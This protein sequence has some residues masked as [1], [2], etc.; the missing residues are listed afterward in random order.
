MSLL[1]RLT[2]FFSSTEA[3]AVSQTGSQAAIVPPVHLDQPITNPRLTAAIQKH[4]QFGTDKTAAELFDELTSSVLLVGIVLDGVPARV[5]GAE[6]LFRQGDRIGV[7]EVADDHDNTLLGLFTDQ[8]QVQQFTDKANSTVVLPAADAMR[9]VLA[10]GY[11]GLVV[12]PASE[13]SLRL[14]AALIRSS[15]GG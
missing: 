10:R 2:G 12:N 8:R 11:D 1:S 9:F 5:S 13:A 7:I 14:D 6:V 4:R 15:L 3:S